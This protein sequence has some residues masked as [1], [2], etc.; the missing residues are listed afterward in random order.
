MDVDNDEVSALSLLEADI[1]AIMKYTAYITF[2][3]QGNVIYANQLFCDAIGYQLNE[4]EGKHHSMFC[5]QS[6]CSSAE[7][8]K[9]WESLRSGIPQNGI[10][11]RIKKDGSALFIS[12]DYF[13]V[14][15]KADNVVKIIKIARDITQETISRQAQKAVL[16]ALERSLAVIEF[17]PDGTVINANDNF[18]KTV[19]YQ[20]S[21]IEGKH[22]KMFCSEEFYKKYPHF[23]SELASGDFKKGRYKRR[24]SRGEIIWLE[25][26]YNPIFD[27]QGKVIKIIKFASDITVR[28]NHVLESIAL[29]SNTSEETTKITEMAVD[30]LHQAIMTSENVVEEVKKSSEVGSKLIVQS[31]QID[32]IVTTIQGIAEQTN[33]L[34][35]NAAIE[36]ARA[37]ELGRGFAVV[38]D[39]VRVLA[40]R[41][42]KATTEITEV[43]RSNT[44]MIEQMDSSLG[45]VSGI[46]VQG[47]DSITA[48]QN[49]LNEVQNGVKQFVDSVHRLQP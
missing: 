30:V 17:Y 34:A 32:Q 23:W 16:Q 5:T 4:I 9:H 49:G 40:N 45:N 24:N 43:V 21:D 20:L 18:L 37:G 19:G 7:Y 36:A 41:T 29:A 25:A 6:H 48:V 15:D 26:T 14:K 35:L 44:D 47:K 22:H 1:N 39:E 46:A 31:K 33:L 42:A 8:R 13:P 2:S 28:I 3:P 38:A 27:E 10:F 11:H 12:A